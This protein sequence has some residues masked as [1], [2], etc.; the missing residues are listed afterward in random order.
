MDKITVC[1]E[2]KNHHYMCDYELQD[3]LYCPLCG[4][5]GHLWRESGAG[6]FYLGS[7]WVCA[8][9]G[10]GREHYLDNS[11]FN[12]CLQ[13]D[14]RLNQLRSGVTDKPTTPKGG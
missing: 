11:C 14:K 10:C 12:N 5:K 6:D 4:V 3:D 13:E 1:K 8:A 2:Y 9:Q 7:E